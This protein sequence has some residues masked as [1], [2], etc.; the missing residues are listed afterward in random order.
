MTVPAIVWGQVVAFDAELAKLPLEVQLDAL[1]FANSLNPQ[2]FGG[3]TT[4][5]YKLARLLYAAH[6]GELVLRAMKM[7]A[8]GAAGAVSSE[9]ISATSVTISYDTAKTTDSLA[10]TACGQAFSELASSSLSRLP[11]VPS[12]GGC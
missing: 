12:R 11:F 7:S 10:L 1:A 5:K 8:S 2:G 6:F 4:P 3:E 9:T